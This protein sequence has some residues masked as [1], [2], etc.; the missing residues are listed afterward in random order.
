MIAIRFAS[1]L[2]GTDCA[3]NSLCE[4]SRPQVQKKY[5]KPR[6]VRRTA[7]TL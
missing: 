5:L 6:S 3:K 1:N 2:A 4:S 7:V